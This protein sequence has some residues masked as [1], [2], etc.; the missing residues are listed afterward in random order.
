MVC[1]RDRR[2]IGILGCEPSYIGAKPSTWALDL[3]RR[4]LSNFILSSLGLFSNS[5]FRWA[6][7]LDLSLVPLFSHCILVYGV[8][9]RSHC[10]HLHL[11]RS[12]VGASIVLCSVFQP[13]A[14]PP[15]LVFTPS[16]LHVSSTSPAGL[17]CSYCSV[18]SNPL[19]SF[20]RSSKRR[21]LL[22]VSTKFRGGVVGNYR[23]RERRGR[24]TIRQ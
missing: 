20:T 14:V 1:G 22:V 24:E 3:D 10:R 6:I 19:C 7:L 13:Q 2:V 12:P 9:P 23:T 18:Q 4:E 15:C 17:C 21:T 11:H 16:W 8:G 5:D